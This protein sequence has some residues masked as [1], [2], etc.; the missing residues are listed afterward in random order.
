M[1]T[2]EVGAATAT[3]PLPYRVVERRVETPET[4]TITLAP[5]RSPLAPFVPGQFA[6]VYAF[7]V[8]DIPLS[9]CGM[10]GQLLQHTVRT[11]GAVSGALHGVRV[12]DTL[13]IRGPFGTGWELP[14]PT[15]GDLLVVAGGIGMAP[16]RPLVVDAIAAPDRYGRL[17]LLI[18]ARTPGDVLYVDQA[19]TWQDTA[20]VL[21]TVDFPDPRWQGDVGLVTTLVDRA[22]FDP[23]TVAAFICGPEPMIRATAHDLVHRGVD[24]DRIQV[25]LERTMHCG[26]GLCGHCQ[27]GPLLLCRD[28]P[29]ITWTRAQPLL[30]IREL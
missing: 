12:G 18:G 17:N 11:V 23:R 8:G 29:V 24:P 3:V 9:V 10:D 16:L 14:A 13:G 2:P 26:S 21:T 6:M 4:A 30:M 27:L 1:T 19:R 5:A 20:C 7:G 15:G 22:A 28:G 25:S